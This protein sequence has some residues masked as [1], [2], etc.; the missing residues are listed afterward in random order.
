MGAETHRKG[1]G[2]KHPFAVVERR[3]RGFWAA[4]EGLLLFAVEKPKTKDFKKL[5]KSLKLKEKALF[6]LDKIDDN[7][8]LASRNLKEISLKRADDVN[9]MDVLRSK[10]LVVTKPALSMLEKKL[11]GAK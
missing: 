5:L 3:W 4:P 2:G 6:V 1:Q 7:L 9:A 8:R 10:K 11:A